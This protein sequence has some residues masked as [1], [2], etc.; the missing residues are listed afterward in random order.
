MRKQLVLIILY[1][2]EPER[3]SR[4]EVVLLSD[5]MILLNLSDFR[6]TD[7]NVELV[8]EAEGGG[9]ILSIKLFC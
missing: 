2:F 3:F 7:L 1:Y 4:K 5:R 9:V 8:D 6:I